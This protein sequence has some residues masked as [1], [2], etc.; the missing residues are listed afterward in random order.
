MPKRKKMK[1]MNRTALKSSVTEF[2]RVLIY[3]F[4][5]GKALMLL[6]G[7]NTLRTLK[8]LRLATFMNGIS[9]IKPTITTRVSS[10]FQ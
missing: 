6:R 9:S 10:Q 1:N 3:F 4:K 7:L 2:S 5:F 8:D